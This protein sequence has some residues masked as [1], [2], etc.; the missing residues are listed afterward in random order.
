MAARKSCRWVNLSYFEERLTGRWSLSF[1]QWLFCAP[2]AVYSS[3]DRIAKLSGLTDSEALVIAFLIIP[4]SALS[5][6][7]ASEF[8]LKSRYTTPQSFERIF[9]AYVFISVFTSFLEMAGSALLFDQKPLIGTQFLTPIF[10]NFVVLVATATLISELSD[11]NLRLRKV[12]ALGEELALNDGAINAELEKEKNQL[13]AGIE[14]FLIPQLS[15]VRKAL[16]SAKL[17]SSRDEKLAAIEAIEEFANKSVRTF[18]HEIY[19]KEISKFE[20]PKSLAE[21][22]ARILSEIYQPYISIKL[23]I[24]FGVLIG[25]S[26]NLSFNG[27]DGLLYNVIAI[28]IITL[29]GIISNSIM[30]VIS[31][32]FIEVKYLSFVFHLFLVGLTSAIF[33]SY[34]QDEIFN[35]EF[36]YDT[37]QVVYRNVI[38]VLFSS[39][40][41]TL[42][43]GR[44]ELASRAELLNVQIQSQMLS[45]NRLL[46]DIR[47]RV[48]SIIHGQIQGRLSGIALALRLQDP[49]VTDLKKEEEISNLL[50]LVENELRSILQTVHHENELTFVSGIEEIRREWESIVNIDVQIQLESEF[51]PSQNVIR[52]VRLALNE[53]ISN[54]VR[55]GR[56]KNIKIVITRYKH[57]KENLHLSISNDGQPLADA[58]EPGLGFRNLDATTA[59]WKISNTESGQV[60]VEA[61]I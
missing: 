8:I 30:K 26:Q 12:S 27:I 25:G 18:S 57:T 55:H 17:S 2:L 4:F 9:I 53:A 11:S 28:F 41:V 24:V 54:A 46:L 60:C 52:N 36:K 22:R 48:A 59:D 20:P 7:I 47:E 51:N 29:I 32:S 38:N 43:E 58:R 31:K 33:F 42:I 56:A 13:V 49:D 19:E 16:E 1:W 34:L 61:I 40:I 5:Y 39:A 10:P 35:L 14:N 44:K 23:V 37:G 21:K 45:R 15:K 3:H 6:F 50:A